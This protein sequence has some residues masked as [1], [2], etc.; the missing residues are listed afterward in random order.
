M[1]QTLGLAFL[2]HRGLLLLILAGDININPG[3]RPVK[4][5]CGVC[6]KAVKWGQQAIE[7]E[8]CTIWYHKDCMNMKNEIFNA[9]ENNS[10]YIWICCGC[11][12]PNF[13]SS[14]FDSLQSIT[15]SNLF[16]TLNMN[17][18]GLGLSDQ[19]NFQPSPSSSP[20]LNTKTNP[21]VKRHNQKSKIPLKIL[22]VNCQRV[23]SKLDGF[24]VLHGN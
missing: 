6:S 2:N 23:R 7:C 14:L 18:S 19:E 11:C 24:Q 1:L 4:Y 12:L 15:T 21:R 17:T 10:S 5:L 20:K 13:A 22:N 3:P 9:L 16:D 8:E